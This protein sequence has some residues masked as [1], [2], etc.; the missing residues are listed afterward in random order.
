MH[1]FLD[2]LPSFRFTISETRAIISKKH[3]IS[4]VASRVAKRHKA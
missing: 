4:G 3:G 2:V 1:R